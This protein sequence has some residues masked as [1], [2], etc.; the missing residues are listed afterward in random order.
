VCHWCSLCRVYVD[1][2]GND[3]RRSRVHLRTFAT[4]YRPNI[5]DTYR[6]GDKKY[7]SFMFFAIANYQ[8]FAFNVA[9]YLKFVSL[10]ISVFMF[11]LCAGIV[12]VAYVCYFVFYLWL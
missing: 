3:V 5:S 6:L 12:A 7:Q 2:I 9:G 8:L 11:T 1:D 4:T 10:F